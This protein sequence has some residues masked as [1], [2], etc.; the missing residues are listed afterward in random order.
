MNSMQIIYPEQQQQYGYPPQQYGGNNSQQPPPPYG[1]S[2]PQ[3][4]SQQKWGSYPE[5]QHQGYVNPSYDQGNSKSGRP[6][7]AGD[8]GWRSG[9]E[10]EGQG[11]RFSGFSDK[12]TPVFH[13]CLWVNLIFPFRKFTEDFCGKYTES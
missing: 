6:Y 9:A 12:V 3:P 4:Q 5:Q 11:E 7:V 10:A 13:T 1:G 2:Y 8:S